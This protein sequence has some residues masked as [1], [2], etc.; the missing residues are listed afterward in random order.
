[1]R[2]RRRPHPGNALTHSFGG[3]GC[4]RN[5]ATERERERVSPSQ[6]LLLLANTREDSSIS[7]IDDLNFASMVVDDEIGGC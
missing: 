7:Y 3:Y 4:A 5:R 1:M 6:P 2:G